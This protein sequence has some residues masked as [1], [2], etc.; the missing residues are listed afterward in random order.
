METASR[1]DAQLGR[2]KTRPRNRHLVEMQHDFDKSASCSLI[3]TL[4]NRFASF[5][6][7]HIRTC[8][9]PVACIKKN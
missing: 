3:I 9:L 1:R 8:G 6:V 2:K 4:P 7:I 5:E